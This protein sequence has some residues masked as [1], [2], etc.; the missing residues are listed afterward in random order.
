MDEVKEYIILPFPKEAF[1][2]T[3]ASLQLK[4]E[5][6]NIL[7]NISIFTELDIDWLKKNCSMI[8]FFGLGFIQLKINNQYRLHF[9]TKDLQ[10]II[11]EEDIHNHRYDFS[12]RILKGHFSQE[13]FKAI[14]G[15]THIKEDE[16]CQKEQHE[17]QEKSFCSIKSIEKQFYRQGE[18]Y[19]IKHDVF[20]RV[21]PPIDN[22]ITL[23]NRGAYQKEFAQVI[24][25]IGSSKVC[26]FSHQIPEKELWETVERILGK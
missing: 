7:K 24:R 23:L 25:L 26:P 17:G 14:E 6:N 11:G 12:S 10:S 15:N 20:H 2:E 9:Y 21:R 22:C 8:H 4:I 3:P 13:I 19:K 16:S 18:F 1:R 5:Q